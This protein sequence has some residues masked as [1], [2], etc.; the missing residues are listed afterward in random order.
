MRVTVAPGTVYGV[1]PKLCA[2]ALDGIR[3]DNVET[4]LTNAVRVNREAVRRALWLV[5]HR[6][7]PQSV[8]WMLQIRRQS[9]DFIS[10][11]R[12][13]S[14]NHAKVFHRWKHSS[15]QGEFFERG[16]KKRRS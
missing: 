14:A 5:G 13:D 9:V 2:R 12:T 16:G 11:A 1:K 7:R 15:R 4:A 3:S 10:Q 6:S 8:A